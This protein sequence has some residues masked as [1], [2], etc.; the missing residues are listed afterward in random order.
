M[1]GSLRS[2]RWV[3]FVIAGVSGFLLA[4]GLVAIVLFPADDAVQEVRVPSVMGLPFADA[5]RRLKADGLRASL[6]AQRASTDVPRNAV[7]SQSPV[8]GET[9]N[10]GTVIVLDVSEGQGSASA[11]AVPALLGASREDAEERLR[12]MGLQL[13]D[14]TEIASDS[15]RGIVLASTPAEGKSIAAGGRVAIVVSAGPAEL[16]LPDIVGREVGSARGTLE[17][18]GL[19]TVVEH[20]SLSSLPA[21]TVV[22]Q[23]PAAGASIASGGTV[24]LRVSGRP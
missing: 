10:A 16:S 8:A 6:G 5:E 14:V 4:F 15:A 23:S 2:K 9:V 12:S 20:D 22:A 24:T 21:G 11:I 13:G 3:P 19:V 7:V 18:L 1:K 17:Q